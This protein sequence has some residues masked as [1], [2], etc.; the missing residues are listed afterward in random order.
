MKIAVTGSEGFLGWHVR[1]QAFAR[2]IGC[3]PVDR[4]LLGDA[5]RLDAALDGVDAVIHCAGVNRG[6]DAE[7]A[8]GNAETAG[9]LAEAL[10]RIDRPVRTVYA[11]SVRREDD[12]A[13]GRAKRSAAA[14]LGGSERSAP[15][16]SDVVLPNLYGEHGRPHYNSFVAT[17]CHEIAHGRLPSVRSEKEVPLLHAQEAAAVLL[18]EAGESGRRQVEPKAEPRSV[19]EVA[20]LLAELDTEY[21]DGAL[22]DLTGRW[23]T[24]MF[25]T[26]RSHLFPVRYPIAL[27]P[28]TDDR[29]VLFEY[30]RLRTAGGQAFAST[31]MPGAVRGEHVHLRKFERFVIVSGRAEIA[32]RRLFSDRTVRF[33]VDG[34][35]PVAVD[36]PTMWAHRLTALG[37]RPAVGVF[38]TNELYSPD[39]ADTYACPVEAEEE[40]P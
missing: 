9:R 24:T 30:V 5:R 31:T 40:S 38:W 17:F 11:D 34:D 16:F 23:R 13:Y 39:D 8:S 4:S 36:M 28:H 10:R 32:A 1:C 19:T 27:T 15:E 35:D 6:T 25:N 18:Y 2:G 3:V 21:R 22:P 29:G 33:R 37:D 14:V 12:T 7:I 20:E 26:Y